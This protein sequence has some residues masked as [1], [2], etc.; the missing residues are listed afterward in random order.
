MQV[1]F[2]FYFYFAYF[3]FAERPG[4]PAEGL[5]EFFGA[6]VR[7]IVDALNWLFGSLAGASAAFVEGFSR[8]LGIDS[9]ILSIAA[10]IIGLFL[11]YRGVRAFIRRR[12]IAGII[13]TLLGLWLLSALIG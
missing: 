7:W 1:S 2:Y 13:W 5:G 3:Y 10:V 9:G 4:N 6:L 12:I 11:L 8:T